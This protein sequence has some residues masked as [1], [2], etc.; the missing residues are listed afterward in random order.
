MR[1]QMNIIFNFKGTGYY[2]YLY[3]TCIFQ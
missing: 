2:I 1:L 3:Q